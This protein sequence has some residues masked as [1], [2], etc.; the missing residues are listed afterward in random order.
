MRKTDILE[1]V[2]T[3]LTQ[4]QIKESFIFWNKRTLNQG[5]KLKIGPQ[6]FVV[7][8]KGTMVFVDLAPRANWA[9]PSKFLLIAED[10]QTTFI[11]SS[12]P[13]LMDKAGDEW[14]VI[15]RFGEPPIDEYDLQINDK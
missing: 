12:F 15:L 11:D 9:H 14:V 3:H 8:F 7:P 4:Q 2:R 5:E 1:I 6:E 10:L 13:P